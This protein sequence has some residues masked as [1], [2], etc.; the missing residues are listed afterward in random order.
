MQSFCRW[1]L[2]PLLILSASLLYAQGTGSITGTIRDTTGAVVPNASVTL[3]DT[4]TRNALKTTSNSE[5]DYLF[6][7]IP[8]GIYDLSVTAVGFNAYDAKG[9]ILRVSAR[10][11]AD[12]P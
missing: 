12:A 9:I 7:A 1:G 3:T 2:F 5:G 4:G 11:R 6:A 10:T 8:P